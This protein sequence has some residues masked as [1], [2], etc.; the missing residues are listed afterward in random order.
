MKTNKPL[1]TRAFSLI[2]AAIVLGIIGLVI[3]GIWVA[4][5]TVSEKLKVTEVLQ[6]VNTAVM[7]VHELY[8][9]NRANEFA[10]PSAS[11]A[12]AMGLFP[13]SWYNAGTDKTNHPYLAIPA[14]S[15]ISGSIFF[16]GFSTY[17]SGDECTYTVNL[18]MYGVPK[19]P[20]IAIASDLASRIPATYSQVTVS[21]SST[22]DFTQPTNLQAITAACNNSSNNNI[23]L[24]FTL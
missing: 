11:T 20:C 14:G 19:K 15:M 17:C 7:R 4:A 21:A 16:S 5:S 1:R 23:I 18:T 13:T 12:M 24:Y 22:N 2:E 3:G 6:T 9:S 8:P 10:V